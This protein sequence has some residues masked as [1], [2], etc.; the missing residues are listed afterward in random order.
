M[1][2]GTTANRLGR[3]SNHVSK[4]EQIKSNVAIPRSQPRVRGD[5]NTSFDNHEPTAELQTEIIAPVKEIRRSSRIHKN[6][7]S[8][9][10]EK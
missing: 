10:P 1:Q 4:Q 6:E 7:T 9:E 8:A 3:Y 2:A 5:Q